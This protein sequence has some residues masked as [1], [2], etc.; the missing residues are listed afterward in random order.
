MG[1]FFRSL[2]FFIREILNSLVFWFVIFIG[3]VTFILVRLYIN[4]E[5][6]TETDEKCISTILHIITITTEYIDKDKWQNLLVSI[7][8]FALAILLGLYT[9]IRMDRTEKSRKEQ[10]SWRI[11]DN[12]KQDKLRRE[13][14]ARQ[15]MLRIEDKLT[16]RYAEALRNLYNTEREDLQLLGARELKNVQQELNHR[17]SDDFRNRLKKKIADSISEYS[18]EIGTRE[19]EK[20]EPK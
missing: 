18:R 7:E 11:E 4:I 8:G 5:N 14:N 15:D 9:A 20:D 2:L 3:V 6:C 12:E 16:E 10:E 1:K 19:A 17:V 13:D